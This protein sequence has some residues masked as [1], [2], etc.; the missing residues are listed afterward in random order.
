MS[1]GLQGKV[2][3]L[4]GC[5][6]DIGKQ[7][8]STFAMAGASVYGCDRNTTGIGTA[9][10]TDIESVD[11]TDRAAATLWIDR[12]L[13]ERGSLDI[14]VHNAGGVAGQ[15]AQPIERVTDQ[16]WDDVIDVNLN[17]AF[18]LCR[19]VAPRMKRQKHGSIVVLGSMAS[20]RASLTGI[21]AY[22]AAK[23]AVLGLTRQ[24]AQELGPFGI[25]V[26]AIAP[27]FVLTSA[28]R[29][30]WEAMGAEGQRRVVEGA[31]LRDVVTTQDIA[32]A[33]TFLA[34]AQAR[35]ITGQIISVDGGR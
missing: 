15:L 10:F 34:S 16:Q 29:A 1:L 19:A 14:L 17:T 35:M 5:A 7:I 21:Q 33:A 12:I 32:D 27:G 11:L 6:S 8:A 24:L 28:T 13:A 9:G 2:V 26:N 4:S 31:A 18:A 23:H 25:R 30:Q 3:A 20:Y 22:C